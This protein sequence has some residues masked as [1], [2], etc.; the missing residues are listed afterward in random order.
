MFSKGIYD[1]KT[2]P[3]RDSVWEGKP[4]LVINSSEKVFGLPANINF[5][6][7][8]IGKSA[9]DIGAYRK[10]PH[11]KRDEYVIDLRADGAARFYVV[12]ALRRRIQDEVLGLYRGNKVVLAIGPRVRACGEL[13][14]DW[15]Q[16]RALMDKG[17]IVLSN[18]L[19]TASGVAL[20][21]KI[22]KLEGIIAA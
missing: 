15:S 19:V 22:R 10:N 12:D 4:V 16:E 21:F 18:G 8:M 2:M 13:D 7:N 3:G 6:V 1:S 9:V 5:L 17:D 20:R 11:S 14:V